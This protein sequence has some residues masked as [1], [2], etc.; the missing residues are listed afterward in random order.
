MSRKQRRKEPID[1]FVERFARWH[2]DDRAI[3][4]AFTLGFS[5]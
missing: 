5:A 2:L 4:P 1:K 3:A